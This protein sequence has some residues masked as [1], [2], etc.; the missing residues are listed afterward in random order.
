VLGVVGLAFVVR[1]ERAVSGVGA[2][3]CD[4]FGVSIVLLRLALDSPVKPLLLDA[5][6][7]VEGTLER[8]DCLP[9]STKGCFNAP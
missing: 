9:V 4:F 6:L 7:G 1:L 5:P 8:D 2:L 3:I